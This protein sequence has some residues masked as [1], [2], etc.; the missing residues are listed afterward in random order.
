VTS[1]GSAYARL[2]RAILTG[3]LTLIDAAARDVQSV[4]LKD[5]LAIVVLLARRHDRRYGHAA[6]RWAARAI[7]ED[8]LDLNTARRLIA[9]LDELPHTP[10]LETA[11]ECY[12]ARAP[13]R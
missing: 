9:L 4:P 7:L 8:K 11:L 12:A 5:A 13:H 1:Q 3:N 6:A 10:G 2:R